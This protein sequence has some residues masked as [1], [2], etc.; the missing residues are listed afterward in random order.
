MSPFPLGP[1]LVTRDEIPDPQTLDIWLEV[2]GSRVQNSNTRFMIF[3]IRFL[4]SYISR[5]MTL[6]PGDVIATG[7][8][9]GVGYG[10]KPPR[11]LKAGEKGDIHHF[12]G[13]S[14]NVQKR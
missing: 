6:E 4:V 12:R 7:T 11:Y 10:M 13:V 14:P 8:P 3:P 5:F 1:W 9:G 2:D